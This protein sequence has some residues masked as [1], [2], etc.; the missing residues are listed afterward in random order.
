MTNTLYLPELREALAENNK[1]E[2]SEFCKALLPART[3]EFM[4]GLTPLE[5]WEVLRH[6]EPPTRASIFSYLDREKQVATIESIDR[7]EIAELLKELP[8]DDSVD[9]LQ[10]VKPETVETLLPLLPSEERRAILRLQQYPEGT[11]GAMMTTEF[12]RLSEN[13]NVRQAL[14]AISKQAEKLET[15]YYLYVVDDEDHLRGTVSARQLVSAMG[16]PDLKISELIETDVVSVDAGEDQEE[17]AKKVARYDLLAIPVVDHAHHMLGIITHDDVIDVVH[18]E[19]VE[20]A[21]LRGGMQAL[22]QGYMESGLLHLA[23]RR[24]GWLLVF[25]LGSLVA[26]FVLKIH[27]GHL[28]KWEWLVFFIPLVLATGGNTGNQTATLVITAMATGD[29]NVKQWWQVVRREIL[30]GLVLGFFLAVCGFALSGVVTLSLTNALVVACSVQFVAICGTVSGSVLP[31]MFR[32]LGLDPALMSNPFVACLNDITGI[33]I[34]L[35]VA[36]LLLSTLAG[37]PEVGG[38]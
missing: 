4:E 31:L 27:E 6:A 36:R 11:A 10:H 2:L 30:S 29:I 8:V 16:K 17:V 22:E 38:A 18:E 1:A 3:A 9:L 26:A 28:S 5:S 24:G 20:D 21:Q 23:R 33:L 7:L 34:Y 25:F 32:R 15:I 37:Q 19:A 35:A 12:A 13:M 14:E